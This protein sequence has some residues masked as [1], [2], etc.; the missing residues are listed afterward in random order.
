M[1]ILIFQTISYLL[2]NPNCSERVALDVMLCLRVVSDVDGVRNADLRETI[3]RT[4]SMMGVFRNNPY[5]LHVG[6]DFLGNISATCD[7]SSNANKV[8]F[9]F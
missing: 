3:S 4:L 6:F 8:L 2:A 7:G 9:A 5:F 1:I